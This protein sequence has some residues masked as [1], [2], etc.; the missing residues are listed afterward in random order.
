[1]HSFPRITH[2]DSKL[3]VNHSVRYIYGYDKVWVKIGLTPVIVWIGNERMQVLYKE[4]ALFGSVTIRH[5]F[6]GKN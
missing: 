3:F 2:V 5:R 1:M 4:N 6:V